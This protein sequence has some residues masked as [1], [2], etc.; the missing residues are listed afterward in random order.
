MPPALSVILPAWNESAR[1][2]RALETVL[3]HPRLPTDTEVIV[4]DDGST[5]DTGDIARAAGVRTVVHPANLGKG[6]AVRTG[7]LAARGRRRLFC[8]V[9]QATPLDDLDG[10][11]AALDAGADVA[12]GER[13]ADAAGG[14]RGAASRT[15]RRLVAAAA[16]GV[17]DTQCGFKLFT[18][19]AAESLFTRCGVDRYAFDVEVLLMARRLGLRVV[20]VPVRWTPRAGSRLRLGRDGGRMALDVVRIVLADRFARRGG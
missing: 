12:V 14:A 6:A 10:L 18:A 20:A 3:G 17:S 7:M 15:F 11:D 9:D 19:A 13:R 8:D 16:V 1:L 5:D 2:G 4:V